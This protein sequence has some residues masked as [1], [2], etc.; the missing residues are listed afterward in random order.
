MKILKLSK[1]TL[2]KI[3]LQ[4]TKEIASDNTIFTAVYTSKFNVQKI[5]TTNPTYVFKIHGSHT[6]PDKCIVFRRDYDKLYTGEAEAAV[7]KLEIIFAEKT[8]LFLGFSFSDP[9]IN[10][11]FNELDIAFENFIKHYI[12]TKEPKDFEQYKFLKPIKIDDF[13][14]IDEFI[15]DCLK[16]KN[17][18]KPPTYGATLAETDT[19]LS[20]SIYRTR[21]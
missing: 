10:L 21:G 8:I 14:E 9:D 3:N 2:M 1:M 19:D 4:H 11:V 18:N 16:F 17:D 12:I 5:N 15:E 6:E 20:E 13:N 7:K